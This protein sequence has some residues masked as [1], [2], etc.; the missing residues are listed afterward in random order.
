MSPDLAEIRAWLSRAERAEEAAHR[1]LAGHELAQSRVVLLDKLLKDLAGLP[2]DVRDY[3]EEATGCLEIG[4]FRAAIVLA[5]A[6]FFHTVM[7]RLFDDHA[8]DVRN[9]RPKWAF[10][11]LD[12]LKEASSESQLLDVA[13]EVKLLTRSELREYQGQLA[14]RNR[15]AHPTLYSPSLNRA[16]GF[17]DDM[18][19]QATNFTPT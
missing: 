2:V 7:E 3:F 14:T 10:N 12:E 5:W 8:S 15:C 19:R 17:V 18:L 1:V 16:V 6:G 13:R 4:A 9:K 11:D